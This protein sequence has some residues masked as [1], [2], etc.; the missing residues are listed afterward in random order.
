MLPAGTSIWGHNRLISENG[1]ERA[2]IVGN[3]VGTEQRAL[4]IDRHGQAIGIV[5]ARIVQ[6]RVLDAEDAPVVGECHFCVVD[7]TTLV[8]GA[9]EML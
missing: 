1:R 8:G 2:F 9:D 3:M 6:K 7:L 5:C 4:A